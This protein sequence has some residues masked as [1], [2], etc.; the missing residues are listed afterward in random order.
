[1]P[2]H[3]GMQWGKVSLD[4][5]KNWI[6]CRDFHLKD[7]EEEEKMESRFKVGDRVEAIRSGCN[8]KEGMVGYVTYISDDGRYIHVVDVDTGKNING[9]HEANFRLNETPR[10]SIY[11]D[12]T[13]CRK[14]IAVDHKS[15][16]KAFARCSPDDE[17]D[18]Y[19]GAKLALERLEKKEKMFKGWNGKMVCVDA[20]TSRF[21]TAGKVYSVK[22]GLLL[23]DDGHFY[24]RQEFTSPDDVIKYMTGINSAYGIKMIEFKGE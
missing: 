18:F 19:T 7:I 11:L 3:F 21:F 9:C 12:P 17:F 6:D 20:G 13:D 10:I 8:Y 2:P 5:G 22:N 16:A 4:G 14:M 1:M 24:C 23:D 15:K